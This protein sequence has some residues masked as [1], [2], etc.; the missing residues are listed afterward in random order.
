M[1][2]GASFA[3]FSSAHMLMYGRLC[4]PLAPWRA[5]LMAW[6]ATIACSN[7]L[8][9]PAAS[10]CRLEMT[11]NRAAGRVAGEAFDAQATLS[12]ATSSQY[13]AAA[14]LSVSREI[15]QSSGGRVY[16]VQNRPGMQSCTLFCP[17]FSPQS[18]CSCEHWRLQYSSYVR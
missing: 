15:G 12:T 8:L 14:V 1:V 7:P 9:L 11:Q 6:H 2:C 18:R 17:K 4:I 5:P 10:F 3:N 13:A 16:T